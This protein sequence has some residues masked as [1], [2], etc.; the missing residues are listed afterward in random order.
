MDR[1]RS[2]RQAEAAAWIPPR[3]HNLLQAVRAG[4]VA[5]LTSAAIFAA[6]LWL[7]RA[8]EQAKAD[9]ARRLAEAHVRLVSA[10]PLPA[11]PVDR[12][13]RGRDLFLGTCASCHGPEG[14]GMP[15]LGKDLTTSPFVAATGD[16]DLVA[17]IT[18]GRPQAKPIAMPP[19][20]GNDA[21]TPADLSDLVCYLRGLQD[22]RRLP[23]LPPPALALPAPT[24][25][26]KA[27]ALAAAGGDA[28]LAEFIA[29]GSRV[30]AQ[31]CSA[32]H[33]K[34]ARG[35]AGNGKDLISSELCRTA[36]DDDL[37][38]FIKKGRDPGDPANTS[39]VGMPPKGGN[40]A[41]SDDD[42]LDVIEYLRSLRAAAG[43][44]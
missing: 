33:G 18:A 35:I 41:L 21:L 23:A 2:N 30:F 44:K 32:C 4:A 13:A 28:E 34:D 25:Q 11:L 39:G 20:G 16:E 8:S 31:T 14:K 38:A 24:E 10:P 5:S 37:L 6:G 27:A 22:P 26:D 3:S 19:K 17:F 29:H 9:E 43:V 15:G 36:S 42:I 40:P 12:A 7:V 1:E